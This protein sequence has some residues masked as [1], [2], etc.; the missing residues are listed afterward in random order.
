MLE[1]T[2]NSVRAVAD[3]SLWGLTLH[4]GTFTLRQSNMDPWDPTFIKSI[5]P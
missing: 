4:V 1:F 2:Q 3:G 5:F